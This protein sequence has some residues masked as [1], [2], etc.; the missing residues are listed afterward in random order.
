[1]ELWCLHTRLESR[2]SKLDCH[3]KNSKRSRYAPGG[4]RSCQ[5]AVRAATCGWWWTQCC[6]TQRAGPPPQLPPDH[7]IIIARYTKHRPSSMIDDITSHQNKPN[8]CTA[9]E[10]SSPHRTSSSENERKSQFHRAIVTL[11]TRNGLQAYSELI[12]IS[13]ITTSITFGRVKKE[14]HSV[15]SKRKTPQVI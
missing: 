2:K 9:Q 5:H 11:Q 14:H 4:R 8:D 6:R 3:F 13:C 15:V 1:M 10:Q 7:C 12:D